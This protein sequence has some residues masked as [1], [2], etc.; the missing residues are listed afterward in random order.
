MQTKQDVYEMLHNAVWICTQGKQTEGHEMLYVPVNAVC[1]PAPQ[2]RAPEAEQILHE[3]CAL[4]SENQP[5]SVIPPTDGLV[6]AVNHQV[7]AI[8]PSLVI[9]EGYVLDPEHECV[10]TLQRVEQ[11]LQQEGY[12]TL[13][14]DPEEW[15]RWHDKR[16]VR[17]VIR[18]LYGNGAL[19]YGQE[20]KHPYPEEVKQFA[21]EQLLHGRQAIIKIPGGGGSGLLKIQSSSDLTEIEEFLAES[22]EWVVAEQWRPWKFSPCTSF[23][24]GVY[25]EMCDQILHSH[26]GFIGATSI[27]SLTDSDQRMLI[28]FQQRLALTMFSQGMHGFVGID[29]VLCPFQEGDALVLPD[30]GLSVLFV[31]VN[32]RVNGHNQERLFVSRLAKREGIHPDCID[33]IRVLNTDQHFAHRNE[34]WKWFTSV[35]QGYATPLTRRSLCRGEAYFMLDGNTGQGTSYDGVMFVGINARDKLQ[36]ACQF[37]QHKDILY[38]Q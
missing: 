12:E 5:P 30:S 9:F 26:G 10:S 29:T 27:I 21:E 28:T 1:R 37:L 14:A 13:F 22:P 19:P 25:M 18:G 17:K 4:F 34:A 3:L 8:K 7:Q 16:H 32:P 6:E 24:N 11:Q 2:G 33:H 35:L 36:Q 38:T 31:E 15:K 23:F 20:W